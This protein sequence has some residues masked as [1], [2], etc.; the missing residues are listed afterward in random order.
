MLWKSCTFHTS[1]SLSIRYGNFII[2]IFV[3]RYVFIFALSTARG[4]CGDDYEGSEQ[5]ADDGILVL[6]RK[7]MVRERVQLGQR[8]ILQSLQLGVLAFLLRGAIFIVI[9][10]FTTLGTELYYRLS[11]RKYDDRLDWYRKNREKK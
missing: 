4:E 5:K 1:R 9:F 8:D 2:L 3:L 7:R 11:G 6:D 10:L